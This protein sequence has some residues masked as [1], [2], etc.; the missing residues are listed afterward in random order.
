MLSALG[1]SADARVAALRRY[2]PQTDMP[3]GLVFKLALA[4]AEQGRGEAAEALFRDRFFPREEGGTSVRAVFTQ[5]RLRRAETALHEQHC[6]DA[7]RL[8]DSLDRAVPGLEFTRGGLTD[9]LQPSIVQRQVAAIESACGRQTQAQQR[10]ARLA[11]AAGAD[12]GPLQ[13]ALAYDAARALGDATIDAWRS[14]L[15]DALASASR[16]LEA[17]TSSS[18]GTF[19]L[20]LGL[21]LRALGREPEA[22]RAFTDV[23]KLPDRNLSYYYAR[24][25]LASRPSGG[26]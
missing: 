14:R 17:G 1:A 25:A 18:P 13:V 22:V 26:R 19:Q 20:A 5:V 21:L 4:L 24:S 23:F 15:T 8:L 7:L 11:R 3:P 10:L 16:T 9:L 2:P 12:S 6:E